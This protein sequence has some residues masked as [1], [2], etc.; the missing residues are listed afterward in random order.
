MSSEQLNKKFTFSSLTPPSTI[1]SFS[2]SS[3]V[4]DKSFEKFNYSKCTHGYGLSIPLNNSSSSNFFIPLEDLRLDENVS[5][6][7]REIKLAAGDASLIEAAKA[8]LELADTIA[9]NQA[10]LEI[11]LENYLL[12]E[13]VE[14]LVHSKYMPQAIFEKLIQ[15]TTPVYLYG[16]TSDQLN[17]E[18]VQNYFK[19]YFIFFK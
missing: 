1:S 18:V 15:N 6:A 10:I 3:S 13:N 16:I 14:I 19:I 5:L 8:K 9:E 7:H 2:N 17:E 11:N 4:R 12:E